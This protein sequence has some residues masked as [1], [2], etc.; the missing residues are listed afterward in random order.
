[1][2]ERTIKVTWNNLWHEIR[3]EDKNGNGIAISEDEIDAI[4]ED[5][6]NMR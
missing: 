3:L 4:M 5:I 1:M 6:R 2:S